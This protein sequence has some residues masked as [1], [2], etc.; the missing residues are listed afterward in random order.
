MH[1][2]F[3][4]GGDGPAQYRLFQAKAGK[5]KG[6]KTRG[7][8]DYNNVVTLVLSHSVG[9]TLEYLVQND[10]YRLDSASFGKR[11]RRGQNL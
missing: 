3:A 7:C 11:R 2:L 10:G 5:S 6:D 8:F 1:R 4:A 9:S